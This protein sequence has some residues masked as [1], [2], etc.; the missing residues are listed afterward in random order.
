MEVSTPMEAE[1]KFRLTDHVATRQVIEQ[2]GAKFLLRE[3]HCDTYLRHPSRDFRSTD[4]AL[5][6]REINGRPYVTYKGPRLSGPIKVRPEIELPLVEGTVNDWLKIWMSLGFTIARSVRKH[7]DIFEYFVEDRPFTITLDHVAEL[8]WFAE[9]ERLLTH[10]S[11]VQQAET[12]IQ[13]LASA[14]GLGG[15]E[16]RSY[17]GLLLDLDT[18]KK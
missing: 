8:G 7:R 13:H 15:I 4:E 11:E 3:D 14:I 10:V 9:I 16:K 17:L 2:L 18:T 1:C 6:L 5:R 12:E